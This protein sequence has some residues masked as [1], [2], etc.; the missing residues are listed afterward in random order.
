MIL[1]IGANSGSAF[2]NVYQGLCNSGS[3]P[4]LKL[5]N[6]PSDIQPQSSKQRSTKNLN[7]HFNQRMKLANELWPILRCPN[8]R[9]ELTQTTTG[10]ECLKCHDKYPLSA[11]GQLDLRL[12][13]KKTCSL[14]F[15]LDV[16][17]LP[18]YSI[19]QQR[20]PYNPLSKRG[21]SSKGSGCISPE[22]LS[23][24]PKSKTSN[25][26][27][28]DLGCGATPNK[29]ECEKAGFKYVGL[30]FDSS[31][32][33]L[34]GDAHALPFGDKTFEF[35]LSI[36][37]LEHLR[38]PFIALS[39]ICRVLKKGATF[40]GS[41][42][43]LEPYHGN[44]FYHFTHLGIINALEHS[45]FKI[46]RVATNPKWNALNAQATMELFPRMPQPLIQLIL[47]P[48]QIIHSIWW[49]AGSILYP[50][51]TSR[52]KNSINMAGSFLF[53]VEKT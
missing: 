39:E 25:S 42:A 2:E 13:R 31:K 4:N 22:L 32:S 18:K 45:N 50:I 9:G 11:H 48:I 1:K 20:L 44:S 40:I 5:R 10:A 16:N 26:L 51:E 14:N 23:Y 37:V 43:F 28:L 41:V 27:M 17:P 34:L 7:R 6:Y 19:V 53:I 24:F 38:Y 52:I 12:R 21:V 35:V 46:K 29:S 47:A 3:L 36:A 49:K 33:T 30:D 15:D 8:C